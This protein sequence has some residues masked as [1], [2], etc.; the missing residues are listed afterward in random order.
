M[1]INP[2]WD[3]CQWRK[4]QGVGFFR[5]AKP[6]GDI[7][8]LIA[9]R[10]VGGGGLGGLVRTNHGRLRVFIKFGCG[11]LYLLDSTSGAQYETVV[12]GLSFETTTGE[13]VSR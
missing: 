2:R 3:R 8:K 4:P 9:R 5:E 10:W 12:V 7:V 1:R 11:G 6:H 13:K